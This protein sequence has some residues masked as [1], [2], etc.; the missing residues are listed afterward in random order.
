MLGWLILYWC[1]AISARLIIGVRHLLPVFPF[2]IILVCREIGRWLTMTPGLSFRLSVIQ[3][4]KASA[5]AFLLIWQVISVVGVYPSFLAYFNEAVG[6]AQGGERYVVDSN[7]DWGQDL[8]RLREF[9]EAHGIDKM[10]LDYF[11]VA[12]PEYELGEKSIIWASYMGPYQGWLAV[13]ASRLKT[14]QGLW[15]S[16]VEYKP[17]DSYAWLSDIAPVAKIGHSILVFDLRNTK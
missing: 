3:C 8:R 6:A 9:V 16:T 10:A 4:A 7:L 17:E 13:S 15:D 11:G 2:T 1:V 12:A 14:A 5:V